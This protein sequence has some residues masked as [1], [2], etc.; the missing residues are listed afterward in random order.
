MKYCAYTE[1]K[2]LY[3]CT[4]ICYIYTEAELAL[5]STIS[6]LIINLSNIGQYG[7]VA[8]K[9]QTKYN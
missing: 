8:H 5:F 9:D 3:T 4:Y 2:M 1:A 7:L 6:S